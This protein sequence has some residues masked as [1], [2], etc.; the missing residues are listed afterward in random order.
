MTTQIK[1]KLNESPTSDITARNWDSEHW[2]MNVSMLKQ[3]YA[4]KLMLQETC[5]VVEQP[6]H[7]Q[8]CVFGAD[9]PTSKMVTLP[10][11]FCTTV[12]VKFI[13]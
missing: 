4:S 12:H 1:L 8:R 10:R 7:N 11:L 6:P 5:L 2:R 9:V 3:K 13:E